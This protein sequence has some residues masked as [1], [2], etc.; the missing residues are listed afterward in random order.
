MG[1]RMI[2]ISNTGPLI[3]LAKAGVITILKELF[4]E[5]LIPE[6]V[7]VEVV[8]RGKDEGFGD[9][10][11]IEKGI[12]DGWISVV[13][14]PPGMEDIAEKAGIDAG[15]AAAISLALQKGYLLLID[16]LAA[17]RFS[18]GLGLEITGSVGIILKAVIEGKFSREEAI[19]TLDK[20]SETMWLSMEVY[21]EVVKAIRS[22]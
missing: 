3:H 6:A 5:I 19:N 10:F 8:D 22:L 15:E 18:A 20:L 17:R 16:D 11:L 4:D 7:K 9:A 21:K 14:N 12:K 13:S 2:V 1:Y